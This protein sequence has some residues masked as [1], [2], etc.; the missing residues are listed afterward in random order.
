MQCLSPGACSCAP[1]QAGGCT[2]ASSLISGTIYTTEYVVKLEPGETSPSG[3]APFIGL[4]FK[5]AAQ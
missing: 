5:D 4:V 2:N 1:N 3:E